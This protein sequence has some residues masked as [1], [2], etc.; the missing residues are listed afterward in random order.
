[1]LFLFF[2]RMDSCCLGLHDKNMRCE[3]ITI[4]NCCYALMSC[5]IFVFDCSC[6]WYRNNRFWDIW[7]DSYLEGLVAFFL[8]FA[9]AIQETDVLLI[10]ANTAVN[11]STGPQSTVVFKVKDHFF[12]AL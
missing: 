2:L 4:Q 8:S 11:P 12:Y 10:H 3:V 6:C 7:G 1:M 5:Q 9:L